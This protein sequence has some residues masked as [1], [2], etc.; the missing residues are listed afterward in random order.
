MFTDPAL[1]APGDPPPTNPCPTGYSV[2]ESNCYKVDTATR[3]YN[4][5]ENECVRDGGHLVDVLDRA[6]QGFITTMLRDANTDLWI[7]LSDRDVSHMI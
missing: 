3:S 7:G 4:D 6:E 2:W 1:T 5:A